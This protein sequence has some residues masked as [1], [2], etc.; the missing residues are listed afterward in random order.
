MKSWEKIADEV[1]IS[2]ANMDTAIDMAI[3]GWLDGNGYLLTRYNKDKLRHFLANNFYLI[4]EDRTGYIE[5]A[6]LE[7]EADPHSNSM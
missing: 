7:L 4:L 6:G 3:E 5:S 2:M 1:M